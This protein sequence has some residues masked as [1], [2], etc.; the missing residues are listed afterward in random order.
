MNDVIKF[1]ILKAEQFLEHSGTPVTPFKAGHS[2]IKLKRLIAQYEVFW[3]H[4]TRKNFKAKSKNFLESLPRLFDISHEIA[5][6]VIQ[7][8]RGR[9]RKMILDDMQ[10]ISKDR[11]RRS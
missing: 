2:K 8:D 7:H 6:S 1:V 10:F 3:K 11:V 9:T 5:F 4:K